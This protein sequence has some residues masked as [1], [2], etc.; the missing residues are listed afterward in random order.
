MNKQWLDSNKDRFICDLIRNYCHVYWEIEEQQ[1]RFSK[2]GTVSYSV[3]KE[4]L[5]ETISRGSFSRLK[6]TAHYLFRLHYHKKVLGSNKNGC[7]SACAEKIP[8]PNLDEE[9]LDWLIGYAYHECVKLKEDAYQQSY[10]L[11]KLLQLK[12]FKN[13]IQ[14]NI[15]EPTITVKN[16]DFHSKNSP[17]LAEN[18][19][20][21]KNILWL[22]SHRSTT[23]LPA[24]INLSK[25][26]V[27]NIEHALTRILQILAKAQPILI[28]Y[29]CTQ[30]TN[31][32]LARFLVIHENL[33]K[34]VFKSLYQTLLNGLYPQS[35]DIRFI[36]A[37]Q[38]CLAG[39]RYEDVINILKTNNI[40]S[41]YNSIILKLQKEANELLV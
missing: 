38:S 14:P 23:I 5:D 18:S 2:S 8:A 17:L 32:T 22:L 19:L 6:D 7:Q 13:D 16:S 4:L 12:S 40:S 15:K 31:Y 10:Y 37:A 29:L 41:D 24:F 34:H 35:T 21:H 33:V 11:N 25:Q 1:I 3:L 27:N 30:K 20:N 9:T 28:H 36:L 26:T 39:G